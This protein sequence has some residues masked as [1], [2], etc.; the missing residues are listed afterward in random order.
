MTLF[1][2]SASNMKK[3]IKDYAIYFFTLVLGV[4]IFYVFNAIETQ[5]AMLRISADTR[6]VVQLMSKMIA[7]VSVFI[8]FVLGFLI[9]YASRFLMK[10]RNKEFGLY[11]IL[12]MGKRKVST[13]LFI[14]TLIIGLVSLVVGLLVGIGISQ[15]TSVLVANM[16]DV[17]MSS[18][19]FVFS[20]SA[21]VKTCLYFAIIYVVVI[22]FNTFIISKCK[23][24]DLFQNGRKS[25]NVK[26]K[27]PWVSVI[28]FLI[29][30]V[31][32]GYAYHAVITDI[33][34][35]YMNDLYKWIVVGCVA[36]VLFFWSV[37]GMLFRIVSSMKNVY[38]K[39]LNSFVVRQMSSR[40]NTNVLSISVICL[41][42]FVTICVLSSALA[43]KNS[44]NEGIAKYARAD[45]SISKTQ[46]SDSI[47]YDEDEMGNDSETNDLLKKLEVTDGKSI[48]DVYSENNVD[49]GSYFSD[50]VDVHTYTCPALTIR[51]YLGDEAL[52]DSLG[53]DVNALSSYEG[54][55]EIIS[56][57]D[58]N[59]VAK[60]YDNAELQLADDE[61]AI[62][63]NYRI[64]VKIRDE[65]LQEGKEIEVYG[66]KLK[67]V[68][69][70]CI[71]GDIELATQPLNTGVFIVPDSAIEGAQFAK[72]YFIGSESM[73]IRTGMSYRIVIRS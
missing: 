6:Q 29:S 31:S 40:V 63:A 44:L 18:Y 23:L 24:I 27:N 56:Q 55:E 30:V 43:V 33:N 32:L 49:L 72:E 70:Y 57:S 22:I 54:T 10:R 51:N 41:M 46:S 62:L 3:S 64:F 25:E 11:L 61:Y 67:P 9:I 8:A 34:D 65:R 37:S 68:I 66:N 28:V 59:K 60:I 58:Y 17:D 19:S 16:F 4:A 1:K 13:M 71:D 20:G 73:P 26:I 14:E 2:L 39:G 21:F 45:V 69:S 42:L 53:I 12:G 7:G 47:Y 15:I 36:T 50:Y 35:M 52:I 38:Y 5:T 48:E